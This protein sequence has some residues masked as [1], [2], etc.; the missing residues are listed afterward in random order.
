MKVPLMGLHG[1]TA[2]SVPVLQAGSVVLGQLFQCN[3]GL[4]PT[5][6]PDHGSIEMGRSGG[7]PVRERRVPQSR[8][9]GPPPG[10]APD[11]H[12]GRR[13]PGGA[14]RRSCRQTVS[15]HL[16]E[17]GPDVAQSSGVEATALDAER[18]APAAYIACLSCDLSRSSPSKWRAH[19]DQLD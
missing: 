5:R 18:G 1:A 11:C 17:L 13:D 14:V 15:T 7:Q 9:G 8:R 12:S 4:L 2:L 19:C 3:R 16:T 6:N 10:L